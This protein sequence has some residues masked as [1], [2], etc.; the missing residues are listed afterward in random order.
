MRKFART[1][2]SAV[3]PGF[4]FEEHRVGVG[5]RPP[6]RGGPSDRGGLGSERSVS[7]RFSEEERGP[8]TFS[9]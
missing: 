8:G 5:A 9:G 4:S 7:E 3:D 6:S 2:A 1:S